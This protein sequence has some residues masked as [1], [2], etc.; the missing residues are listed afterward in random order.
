[1]PVCRLV[2]SVCHVWFYVRLYDCLSVCVRIVSSCAH[3]FAKRGDGLP[4]C[5]KLWRAGS[6]R[7]REQVRDPVHVGYCGWTCDAHE[8]L[9]TRSSKPN[10]AIDFH[11]ST[12]DLMH[13]P[14]G[15]VFCKQ[16]GDKLHCAF[17]LKVLSC[18]PLEGDTA[19]LVGGPKCLCKWLGADALCLPFNESLALMWFLNRCSQC[20]Q[21]HCRSNAHN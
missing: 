18:T 1:M 19:L 12:P 2:I 14:L 9:E 17:V 10:L 6:E 11:L 3:V 5:C 13:K 15:P 20:F 8:P 4:R 16:H 7:A 21:L